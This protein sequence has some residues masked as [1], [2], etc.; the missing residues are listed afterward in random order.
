[1]AKVKLHNR[2]FNSKTSAKEYYMELRAQID[3]KIE[4]GELFEELK[5][6]YER[7]CKA[8]EWNIDG[9]YITHFIVEYELRVINGQHAQHKCYKVCFSNNETR[10]F[11]IEKALRAI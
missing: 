2:A 4:G 10:P 8:T 5:E 6:L 7:Y 3:G 11:S 9:R 1:M